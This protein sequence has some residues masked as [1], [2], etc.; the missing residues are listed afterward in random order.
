MYNYVPILYKLLYLYIL[1]YI[2][3]VI[4]T[5]TNNFNFILF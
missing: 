3:N 4:I 2:F 5:L 1:Y